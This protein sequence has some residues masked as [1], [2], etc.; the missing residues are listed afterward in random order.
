MFYFYLFRC[1]DNT[2]YAGNTN[3]P[4]QR[5]KRHNPGIGAQWTKQ[6]GGGKIVYTET[7][8]TLNE[9]IQREIQVKKWSRIKREKLILGLKP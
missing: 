3:Y 8:P 1:E 4:P 5:E 2:L 9:A 7:Y 6:H